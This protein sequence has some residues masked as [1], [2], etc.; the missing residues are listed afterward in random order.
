MLGAT[1]FEM[2]KYSDS[3]IMFEKSLAI[4]LTLRAYSNYTN[5]RALGEAYFWTPG[6]RDS[7]QAT[8][9]ECVTLVNES[10]NDYPNRQTSTNQILRL[11]L[12][13]PADLSLAQIEPYPELRNLRTH[14]RFL[15]LREKYGKE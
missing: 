12:A 13:V 1:L 2:D 10:L 6:L 11:D 3:E 15:A 7:S 8:F 5:W 14:P 4:T 9:R